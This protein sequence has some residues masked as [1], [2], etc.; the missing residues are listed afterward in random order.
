M[1]SEKAATTVNGISQFSN[2]IVISP[3]FLNSYW[4]IRSFQQNK[5]N[6]YK[7]FQMDSPW[8]GETLKKLLFYFQVS[9]RITYIT[10]SLTF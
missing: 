4:T 7:P 1:I 3:A 6:T 5:Q 10:Y 2:C 8:K 9:V